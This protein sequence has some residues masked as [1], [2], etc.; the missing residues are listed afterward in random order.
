M[1]DT[2]VHSTEILHCNICNEDYDTEDMQTHLLLEG[3]DGAVCE[4]CLLSS[5]HVYMSVKLGSES[6]A[7]LAW[8]HLTN[9]Y[10][11]GQGRGSPY[12][13]EE[14]DDEDLSTDE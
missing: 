3:E 2:E 10:K 7:D 8:K 9:L 11:L 1:K 14:D 13:G 12:L 6:M 5:F 4:S